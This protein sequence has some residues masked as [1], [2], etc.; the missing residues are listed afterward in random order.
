MKRILTFGVFDYFHYG[1]LKLL[2]RC[3]ALGDYLIV[4]VQ[5]GEEIHVNKPDSIIFYDTQQR[6]E[7]IRSLRCVDEVFVYRQVWE[8]VKKIDF[9]LLVVGGDQVHDGFQEAMQWCQNNGKEVVRLPR[10]PNISSSQIKKNLS[11]DQ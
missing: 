11:G 9:D 10:T 5:D 1:H 3:K 6:V 2:E 7:I 8:D 4:A